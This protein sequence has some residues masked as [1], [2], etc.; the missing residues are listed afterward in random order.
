[1][2]LTTKLGLVLLC[3]VWMAL[4]GHGA[5]QTTPGQRTENA[6][7]RYWMAFALMQDPP[8]DKP[9]SDLLENVASGKAPWS[10]AQLG[11]ILDANRLAIQ[12]LQRGTE[13]SNCDWGLEYELGPEVPIA[14][15]PRARVLAR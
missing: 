4:K 14:H 5:S 6:A 2:K 11:P 1:M 3:A 13:L 9:T 12:T 15:L 10:E 7:L 8:A